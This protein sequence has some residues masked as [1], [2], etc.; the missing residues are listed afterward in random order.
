MSFLHIC[1]RNW[2]ELHK[3]SSLSTLKVMNLYFFHNL[4]KNTKFAFTIS[5]DGIRRSIDHAIMGSA[6]FIDLSTA[7]ETDEH[8]VYSSKITVL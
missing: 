6:V 8:S 5:T 4:R 1:Q 2:K 3:N 7:Y